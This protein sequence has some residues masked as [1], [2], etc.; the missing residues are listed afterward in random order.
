MRW[1][2]AIGRQ[3]AA[4][5][6]LAG[7]VL[8]AVAAVAYG[9]SSDRGP[10]E[11]EAQLLD[12]EARAWLDAND[13]AVRV[14][15]SH[16]PPL[17]VVGEDGTVTG[18]YAVEAWDLAGLKLGFEVEHVNAGEL[19][20]VVVA[21]DAG[22]VDV[23][24]GLGP[25][26]DVLQ[27]ASPSRPWAWVP[28]VF[29]GPP[30]A[31]A[32]SGFDGMT[33]TT[34]PGSPLVEQLRTTH[35]EI[36]Y[37]ETVGL[38][39]GVAAVAAGDIDLYFGP[40]AHV[41]AQ[42]Q[43][44]GVD[45]IPIGDAVSVVEVSSWAAATGPGAV[46]DA[47]RATV[48]ADELRLLHVRWTGFDLSDPGE[49]GAAPAWLVPTL[50]ALAAAV[51]LLALTAALMRERVRQATAELVDVNEHLEEV[52]EERTEELAESVSRLRR[53]NKALKRFTSTAAHDL[54]GPLTAIGG[55]ADVAIRM[56]LPE[57]Q[58]DDIL[59]RV[60][61]SAQRLGRMIDDMLEDAVNMGADMAALHG[62]DFA[63]WLREVTA[64]ELDVIDGRL[65]L[66]VPDRVLDLDV[67]VLR[68]SSINLVGNAI[69][70]AVNQ[71]GV[72]LQVT[73]SRLD[74][75][76]ELQVDD[77]GPGVP[78]AMWSEIFE[79]G[80]RLTNDDRG[81]GLGLAAIRDLV[82]GAGGSIRVG[83][84]DLGGASFVVTFPVVEVASADATLPAGDA[85]AD[86]V[87]E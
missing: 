23:A 84:S 36:T 19:D 71:A 37:I 60:R 26:D 44:Q 28:S 52:V 78:F 40:L 82:Q 56:D 47:A 20:D 53:S 12:G 29:L 3:R 9:S 64:P 1:S 76:W 46:M 2:V 80:N 11:V 27:V 62:A 58:G 81:F 21:L 51:L 77:N 8:V 49:G 65:E 85:V 41:G 54:K 15:W 69:K 32:A 75:T 24:G 35:P 63:D 34:V 13:G 48:T 86:P 67:E 30:S 18:G 43:E 57:E 10:A 74:D 45:L 79:R 17:S 38:A 6:L 83:D 50:L 31:A 73:L 70:Y 25:R 68:R 4:G 59:R 7:L 66:E 72:V 87:A 16:F 5:W 14:G 22:D 42:I 61:D 33:A 55:L 39:G